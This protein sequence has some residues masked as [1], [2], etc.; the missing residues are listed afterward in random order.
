VIVSKAGRRLTQRARMK[1]E[2]KGRKVVVNKK[3]NPTE[4]SSA[5]LL[6]GCSEYSVIW[7]WPEDREQQEPVAFA[8]MHEALGKLYNHVERRARKTPLW[9]SGVSVEFTL[10]CVWDVAHFVGRG[11][12]GMG[13]FEPQAMLV[14][15]FPRWRASR[16]WRT[17]WAADCPAGR[18]SFP[19]G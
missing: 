18:F 11:G 13:F 7:R 10:F 2:V 9:V 8:R 16:R 15:S 14:S 3:T 4:S 19:S 1:W 17:N 6:W 12:S 5:R